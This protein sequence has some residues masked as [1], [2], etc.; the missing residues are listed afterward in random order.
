ME[1]INKEKEFRKILSNHF[2]KFSLIPIL[3]VEVALIILYFLLI[4]I[5]HQKNKSTFT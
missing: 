5:F 2:I 4:L 1:K 3:V